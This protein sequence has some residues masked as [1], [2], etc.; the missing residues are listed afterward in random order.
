MGGRIA[1][2]PLLVC[3]AVTV[4]LAGCAA[5]ATVAPSPTTSTLASPVATPAASPSATVTS[6]AGTAT[7]ASL[8]VGTPTTRRPLR[9]P[10]RGLRL[11][12]L[13]LWLRSRASDPATSGQR[14]GPTAA[15]TNRRL[16]RL[17]CSSRAKFDVAR[18]ASAS[19]PEVYLVNESNESRRRWPP[20]WLIA[21]AAIGLYW[22]AL[23][24]GQPAEEISGNPIEVLPFVLA[25]LSVVAAI[26][27]LA[28]GLLGRVVAALIAVTGAARVLLTVLFVAVMAT[29]DSH[30]TTLSLTEWGFL[31]IY[32]GIAAGYGLVL[33]RAIRGR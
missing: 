32:L 27:L 26:G 30:G 12:P 24:L 2:R 22:L 19:S 18:A 4:V 20:P 21:L 25:G 5:G 29:T 9:L 7:C 33:V 1:A 15:A 16:V 10:S 3:L 6:V 28:G 13:R 31:A 8:D 17:T 14:S 23:G 11:L